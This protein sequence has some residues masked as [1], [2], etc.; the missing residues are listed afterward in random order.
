MW[1]VYYSAEC[2]K[3]RCLFSLVDLFEGDCAVL[4]T[5]T[6]TER[7]YYVQTLFVLAPQAKCTVYIRCNCVIILPTRFF[8]VRSMHIVVSSF[9]MA[10]VLTNRHDE[11]TSV[12][13]SSVDADCFATYICLLSLKKFST[14]HLGKCCLLIFHLD[15]CYTLKRAMLKTLKQ[16]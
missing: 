4:R 6:R 15:Y 2:L 8:L 12:S 13:T 11:N 9:V 1:V 3:D 10:S 7:L 14:V 5:A 16:P